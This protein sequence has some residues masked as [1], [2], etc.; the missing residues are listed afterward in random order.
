MFLVLSH[1]AAAEVPAKRLDL[2]ARGINLIDVFKKPIAQVQ[3]EIEGVQRV[4]FRHIRFFVD[5]ANINKPHLRQVIDAA[6]A[7]RLA[8]ILCMQ[9]Y[10]DE[11]A[12]TPQR[13]ATWTNAW[14]TIARQYGSPDSL[15]FELVN[16]PSLSDVKRW[17]DIQETMRQQIRRIA[18][19][20]TLLLT[21]T[22]ASTSWALA[23]LPPST[24]GNVVYTFHVYAPMVFS[25]QGADW[26]DPSFG[27]IRGLQYPPQQPNL[28]IIEHQASAKRLADLQEY[29]RLGRSIV[30]N[31]V[32]VAA[33]WAKRNKVPM[34]VTEFGVYRAV[35]PPQSRIA[36]LRDVRTTLERS[37]IGWSVWEYNGGFA[38]KPDLDLGCAPLPI[39]LGLCS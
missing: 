35:V 28:D 8:I 31:E 19:H 30:A 21:S 26:A 10:V 2:L 17:A 23:Q 18:P 25:H 39:A 1:I 38:V 27:T 4:G 13:I 33:D 5:P 15:F 22:P 7:R 6:L 36:W 37:H 20:H 32:A 3:A 16:E 12:D 29:G 34:V 14:L 11:F 9:S 24:D